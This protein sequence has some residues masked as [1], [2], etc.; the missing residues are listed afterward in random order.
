MFLELLLIVIMIEGAANPDK[1]SSSIQAVFGR[2]VET[3]Q[4]VKRLRFF[5]KN[6]VR[7]SDLI[8]KKDR[9]TV[10]RGCKVALETLKR[11]D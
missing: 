6:N 3:P 9:E 10:R 7:N 2:T 5:I 1:S 8:A 11:L 4:I